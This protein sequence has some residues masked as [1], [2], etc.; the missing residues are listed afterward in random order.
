MLRFILAL[1]L[2]STHGYH[3]THQHTNGFF[4]ICPRSLNWSYMLI[5]VGNVSINVIFS[6]VLLIWNKC[7][8]IQEKLMVT[9]NFDT[10]NC[11]V[12]Q[13]SYMVFLLVKKLT[14]LYTAMKVHWQMCQH[15]C[16]KCGNN[17]NLQSLGS[18]Y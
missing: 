10:K 4:F 16:T 8:S 12:R 3:P 2:H 5:V 6:Y 18:I 17:K 7:F 15:L 13:T 1:T 14:I 9:H 11:Q